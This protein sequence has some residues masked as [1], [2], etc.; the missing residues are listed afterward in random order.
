MWP[1][2]TPRT[3]LITGC[4]AGF[5]RAIAE[6]ALHRGDQV[7]ATARRPEALAGLMARGAVATDLDVTDPVACRRAVE[8]ALERFGR[9]DVLVNNAGH[10]SVGAVEELTMDELRSLFEV[11][12]F[13]A[14]ELT[15]AVLPHMRERRS[16][17]IVQMSSMGGRVSP[18]AF[19]AY[20]STKWALEAISE[21][22]AA[23]V[24]PFGIR[25]LIVEPGSFRTEFGGGRMH[26][27]RSIDAYRVSTGA[28]RDFID[29]MDGMQPG[30]PAKAA[31]AILRALE[32]ED[33]PLRLPLGQDAVDAIRTHHEALLDDVMRWET[34]SVDTEVDEPANATR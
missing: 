27:S 19:G 15:K 24:A 3:W 23:E 28:N 34:V 10:G 1:M 30:D 6:A 14:V 4:S 31:A 26:R 33:A 29:G 7:L 18:P 22:L 16:G 11:M 13:G 9:I 25:V 21:S 17:S 5:G 20:C 12:F 8:V 32:A 2:T